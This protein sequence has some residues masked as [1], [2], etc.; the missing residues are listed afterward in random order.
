MLA[1][2]DMPCRDLANSALALGEPDSELLLDEAE[3]TGAGGFREEEK[4][5]T[6]TI[7]K[8]K[9]QKKNPPK[10]FNAPRPL[11]DI[12]RQPQC[13]QFLAAREISFPHSPHLISAIVIK[14]L[15]RK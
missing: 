11:P 7:G 2:V 14:S 8:T 1:S 6:N 9:K 13:G 3:V 5:A 10:I 12:P 4:Q 15:K